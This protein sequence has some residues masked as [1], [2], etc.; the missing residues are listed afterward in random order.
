MSRDN[1]M[2]KGLL[3]GFLA[4]SAIGAIIALLYAPKSGK[5]LRGDLKEKTDEFLDDAQ[6]YLVT[7]KQKAT[8]IINDGKK[9]SERLVADAKTKVDVLLQD[10]EKVLTEAKSK[11][12]DYVSSGKETVAKESEKLKSA[13][14]AGVDAYK[15]ET[16]S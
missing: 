10:A 15:S 7:A 13:F 5:E 11:A 8:E 3:V 12:V 6:E 1:G 4:G 14:K 9:K 2:G 16:K